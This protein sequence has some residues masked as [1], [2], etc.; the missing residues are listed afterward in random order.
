MSW[1]RITVWTMLFLCHVLALQLIL[2]TPKIISGGMFT[3]W[4][5]TIVTQLQ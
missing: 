2:Q 5:S 4:K 1:N 3:L